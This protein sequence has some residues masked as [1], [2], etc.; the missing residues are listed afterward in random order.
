MGHADAKTTEIY[1]HYAPDP[2]QG[3][4]FAERAFGTPR[5]IPRYKASETAGTSAT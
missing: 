1:S 2:S 5:F 3:A 4:V